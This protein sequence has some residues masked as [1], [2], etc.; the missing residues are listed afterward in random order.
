MRPG[1]DLRATSHPGSTQAT[2]GH[3]IATAGAERFWSAVLGSR[4]STA[5]GSGAPWGGHGPRRLPVAASKPSPPAT[6]A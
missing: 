5:R 3:V 2:P 4:P 6:A 1:R